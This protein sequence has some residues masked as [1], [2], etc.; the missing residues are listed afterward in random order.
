MA[1]DGHDYH[2][3]RVC[4]VCW[5]KGDGLASDL[6]ISRFK[7][8][9]NPKYNPLKP[10]FATGICGSCRSCLGRISRGDGSR[11][12]FAIRTENPFKHSCITR[13]KGVCDCLICEVSKSFAN[14]VKCKLGRK[15]SSLTSLDASSS[16]I[17]SCSPPPVLQTPPPTRSSV[18]I[19]TSCFQVVYPG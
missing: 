9:A 17:L 16:S 3:T 4:A 13:S 1:S 6:D 8:F 5:R 12:L 15:P 14:R 18:E 11:H 7:S 2:R 10:C 19:C